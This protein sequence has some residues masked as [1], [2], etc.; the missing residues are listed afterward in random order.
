MDV[1]AFAKQRIKAEGAG[2][3]ITFR[4]EVAQ[5]RS[6]LTKRPARPRVSLARAPR[7]LT[8]TQLTLNCPFN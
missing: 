3:V 5:V 4:L 7:P 1:T 8:D 6:R 2:A